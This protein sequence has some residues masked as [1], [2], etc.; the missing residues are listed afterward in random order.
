MR[1][2]TFSYYIFNCNPPASFHYDDENVSFEN[3]KAVQLFY[4]AFPEL[5]NHELYLS[6]ESY[7]G[8]Y[9]PYLALRIDEFNRNSTEKI[10]LKGFMIGNGVTNWK[11]DVTPAFVKMSY[12]HGLI[13]NSLQEKINKLNCDFAEVGAKPQSLECRAVLREFTNSVSQV[14]PYDIYRPQEDYYKDKS[15]VRS[16]EDMLRFE[17][18]AELGASYA[19]F[20]SVFKERTKNNFEPVDQ[21]MNTQEVKSILNVPANNGWKECSQINYTMLAKATQ[22]I[23]P[24]LKGRYRMMHYSGDTDGVVP[25]I[26]TIGWMEDLGWKVTKKHSAW[27]AEKYII[28]GYTESREGLDFITIHGCG[29]MAPQWKRDP[30]FIAISS[31]LQDKDLPRS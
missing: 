15:T 6:G 5:K 18:D 29:H 22:W 1:K 13:S 27:M 12:F 16:V 17:S 8:I 30:S 28:G 26:G 4:E 24:Q 7:G 14:Y 20:S 21:Y 10:N 11:Y 2:K 25:T 23:Y 3:L 9:I 31:W 19:S